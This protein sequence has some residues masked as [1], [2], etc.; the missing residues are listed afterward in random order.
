MERMD[1]HDELIELGCATAETRGGGG[2][3]DDQGL[4]K[5]V[6]GLTDD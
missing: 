5:F 4:G 6:A 3:I 1:Q 2:P